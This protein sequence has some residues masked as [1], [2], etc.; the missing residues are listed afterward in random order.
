MEAVVPE[1]M[2]VER[3]HGPEMNSPRHR[4][5]RWLLPEWTSSG[6]MVTRTGLKLSVS[7]YNDPQSYLLMATTEG[8]SAAKRA[9]STTNPAIDGSP[10]GLVEH[11]DND[12]ILSIFECLYTH[13]KIQDAI[14]FLRTCKGVSTL[15]KTEVSG[16]LHYKECKAKGTTRMPTNPNDQWP[17]AHQRERELISKNRAAGFFKACEM[18]AMHC[19]TSCCE[20]A[21]NEYNRYYGK[22]FCKLEPV[23]VGVRLVAVA[24]TSGDIFTFGRERAPVQSPNSRKA[25]H[26]TVLRKG[27]SVTQP[28]DDVKVM[29]LWPSPNGRYLAFTGIGPYTRL[30]VY[31]WDTL[32][33]INGPGGLLGHCE[34]VTPAA[35]STPAC[36]SL[37]DRYPQAV[38]WA[39]RPD[40][41]YTLLVAWS[42]QFYDCFGVCMYASRPSNDAAEKSIVH[43]YEYGAQPYNGTGNLVRTVNVRNSRDGNADTHVHMMHGVGPDLAIFY[44]SYIDQG[45]AAMTSQ[46]GFTLNRGECYNLIVI[47][48]MG[49]NSPRYARTYN[50]GKVYPPPRLD[51]DQEI[52]L[53]P[54]CMA[55][56]PTGTHMAVLG[57]GYKWRPATKERVLSF[58]LY[59]LNTETSNFVRKLGPK[60]ELDI[61]LGPT[62]RPYGWEL[63]FS[64]CGAYVALTYGYNRYPDANEPNPNDTEFHSNVAEAAVHIIHVGPH[65]LRK[66]QIVDCPRIR[67]IAWSTDALV[68]MPRYGAI[69]L[70]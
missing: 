69:K 23:T 13:C 48:T 35:P 1:A 50:P 30:Q 18:L 16:R 42:A 63:T 39:R 46:T 54:R 53:M 22:K 17:F 44:K 3:A 11:V 37:E 12:S 33:G 55:L 34:R 36:P 5:S 28:H 27:R 29:A 25:T 24:T 14:A 20:Q 32:K 10:K 15:M 65:G 64:P 4:W 60:D 70:V 47:D 61:E 40:G 66:S 52:V 19:A 9:S 43:V 26:M 56:S 49:I 57:Q 58:A 31:V 8:P 45:V 38:W 59:T 21:R 2:E 6:A 7:A 41:E 67:Q 51:E 68:V 62:Q